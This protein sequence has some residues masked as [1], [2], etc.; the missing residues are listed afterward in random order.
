VVQKAHRVAFVVSH[1]KFDFVPFQH[2]L[3]SR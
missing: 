3:D 1:A 2:G